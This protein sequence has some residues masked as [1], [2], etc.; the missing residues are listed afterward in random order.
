MSRLNFWCFCAVTFLIQG[1]VLPILMNGVWQPDLW[2]VAVIIAVLAFDKK[3]ALSLAV[4]GGL[5]QDIVTGN[6]FGMHLFPYI[7]VTFLIMAAVRERY[8]RQWFLSVV[9][10]MAGTLVYIALL[11]V[12]VHIGGDV[13]QPVHYVFYDGIPQVFMNGA[14]AVFLHNVLWNMK[15]E[16]EPRW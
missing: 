11:W 5:A 13:V 14:A 2:L 16:W 3:T 8:N 4:V 6:F 15:H 12:V 10:V 1:S 9:S 7:M